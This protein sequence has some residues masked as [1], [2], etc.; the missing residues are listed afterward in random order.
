VEHQD[1]VKAVLMFQLYNRINSCC[2][3]GQA[4]SCCTGWR[5]MSIQ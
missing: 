4:Y 1:G 5:V 2:V 3:S